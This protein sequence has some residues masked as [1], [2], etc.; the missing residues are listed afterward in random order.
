MRKPHAT[1]ATPNTAPPTATTAGVTALTEA[2]TAVTST[3]D[4]CANA[5]A[6][7][8][9]PPARTA[10][11][12]FNFFMRSPLK[13]GPKKKTHP[14]GPAANESTNP[15]LT[16]PPQTLDQTK[17][18]MRRQQHVHQC[19]LSRNRIDRVRRQAIHRLCRLRLRF[20]GSE[21][22]QRDNLRHQAALIL[23][24]THTER[25]LSQIIA[26]LNILEFA[27]QIDRTN[28]NLLTPSFR[29]LSKYAMGCPNLE[30]QTRFL[31]SS[32][33]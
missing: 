3:P 21:W 7:A 26:R 29:M 24:V 32:G 15:L 13:H 9:T 8:A 30:W 20:R 12:I 11:F 10:N 25:K 31:R 14:P 28:D 33:I 17:E 23:S 1:A 22:R 27:R 19:E 4:A 16:R 18:Q 2:V 5:P 6:E